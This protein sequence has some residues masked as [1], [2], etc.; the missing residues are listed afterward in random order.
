MDSALRLHTDR[1]TKRVCCV[2]LNFPP[3]SVASVHRV[4]H[5]AKHL[6]AFGWR[7]TIIC[8]D[9]RDLSEPLDWRLA[10]LVPPGVVV[11]KI[12]GVPLPL[13]RPFGISDLGLR[14]YMSLRR[15]LKTL[16][17]GARYRVVF[18]TGAPF[19][20]MLLANYVKRR[21]GVP[22]VLDFQDPWVS[23]WGA[24][25]L[26]SKAGLSHQ[27][28]RLLEPRALRGA[29]YVT[30]VSDG[31]NAE[32][33]ARY[34]RLD[35]SRMAAIPIGGDRDDFEFMRQWSAEAE[36]SALEPG[37]VHLS[38]VGTFLP[39]SGPL[40][41]V[42]LKAFAKLRS[43]EPALAARVR[44]NFVGTSN[45]PNDDAS[46]RVKPIAEEVG[47][48][49]AVREIP[50]RIPFLQAL[51][52]LAQSNGLLLIGSDEPHY[53]ASK[54]YPALMSGRPFFRC[55][56]ARAARMRSYLLR[57]AGGHWRSRLLMN[58]RRSKPR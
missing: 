47:V 25:Q 11:R 56:T 5:L 16:L 38:Y 3:S 45:Q 55:F 40:V 22:V 27:L 36:E 42:L 51:K 28:A 1:Q 41:R 31:Q 26:F 49:E 21:F 4:R 23:S 2:S 30:S 37:S 58:S 48:A 53:T 52:V 54:I 14:A 39:R 20:Q 19:Y 10:D 50:R 46:Y 13:V 12:R 43:T 6:P 29:S 34:P 35:S 57:A 9:E 7:P 18:M 32:M 17:E 8:I 44:L 24:M 33:V 15:E